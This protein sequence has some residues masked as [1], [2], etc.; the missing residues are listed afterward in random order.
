MSELKIIANTSTS[1]YYSKYSTPDV[2][3]FME[4][5][6]VYNSPITKFE[7]IYLES[8]TISQSK[9]REAGF[10]I[11]RSKDKA[12]FIIISNPIKDVVMKD[13]VE[14]T[15]YHYQNHFKEFNQN[16]VA[17]QSKGYK[18]LYDTELYQYLYK[19]EGNLE[20]FNNVK[21]LIVS[22]NQNNIT[23]AMEFM[24]NANWND[25]QIYLQHL[26]VQYW[27]T[28]NY[29]PYRTSISFKGFLDSLDFNYKSLY[30][31]TASDYGKLCKTEEHHEWVYNLYKDRFEENLNRLMKDYKIKLDKIE[32][33]IQKEY[34]EE[35]E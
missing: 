27:N 14:Y 32:Y 12:D 22:G 34:F 7:T 30:F 4:N 16:L 8:K 6:P 5:I 15:F 3:E 33:S 25:N 24:T 18:Y 26:F 9:L 20:L 2:E 1:Q 29:S 28:M 13:S 11:T 10:S 23:M 35:E 19:Y 17:E 31:G 21:E